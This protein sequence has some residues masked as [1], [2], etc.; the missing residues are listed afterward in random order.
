M[1]EK[2]IELYNKIENDNKLTHN[3]YSYNGKKK[4]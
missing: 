3:I 4:R 2:A 1:A